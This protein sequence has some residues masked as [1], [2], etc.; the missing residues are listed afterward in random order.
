MKRFNLEM[1]VGI[2]IIIGLLCFAYLSVRLGGVSIGGDRYS[3]HARFTSVSGLREGDAVEI[4]GV[5]IGKVDSITLDQET[6]EALVNLSIEK[7]VRVQDDSIASIRTAGIIGGRYVNI[8]P[9][10]SDD[11]LEPGAEIEDTESAINLEELIS[12]YIFEK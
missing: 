6:E 12:K 3:V 7:G 5:Q 2:F 8:S 1:A 9:G 4:A 10:G 11:F